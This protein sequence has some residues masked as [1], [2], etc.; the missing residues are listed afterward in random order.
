M[1][2]FVVRV[3]NLICKTATGNPRSF[4]MIN[5]KETN[6]KK[7]Q[8]REFTYTYSNTVMKSCRKVVFRVRKGLHPCAKRHQDFFINA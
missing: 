3:T 4:V 8:T 2:A 6:R 1:E 5:Q 7:L